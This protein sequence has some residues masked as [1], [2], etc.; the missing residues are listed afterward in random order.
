MFFESEY[1]EDKLYY[2]EKK[3]DDIFKSYPVSAL[4]IYNIDKFG[5]DGFLR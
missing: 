1:A 5:V 3:L 4:S 2:Y